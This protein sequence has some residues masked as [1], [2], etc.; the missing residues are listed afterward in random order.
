ME[1]KHPVPA[2]LLLSAVTVMAALAL[3][4]DEKRIE[5]SISV[6]P[7][8]K[9]L[10]DLTRS[11]CFPDLGLAGDG[12][13]VFGDKK[14][15]YVDNRE[16][17]A[18]AFREAGIWL[19]RPC[20]LVHAFNQ[21]AENPG[22][23]WKLDKK[24]KC[25]WLHPR[26]KFSFWKEYGIKAIVCLNIWSGEEEKKKSLSEFLKWIKA[27]GWEDCISG[28]EMCNEPFYGKDP[29]GFAAYWKD[30]LA[31]IRKE[32]PKVKI[33][34]PLAEYTPGDPDIAAAKARLLGKTKLPRDYFRANSLNQWSAKTVKALGPEL[35]NI[36]HIIYHVYGAAGAYGCSYTG[37]RRFR[38][39]A[40]MFPEV[41]DKRWWITEWRPWSDE[42]LQLQRQFHYVIWAGMYIQTCLCQPELDGFTMHQLS[43]LS[44]VVY[45]SAHGKWSQ[46]Y[47][48]WENGRDLK[49]IKKDELKYETGGM[50]VLF[51]LS[52]QA[53]KTHPLIIGYGSV[54]AG[55]GSEGAFWGSAHYE[56]SGLKKPNCQWTAMVNPGRSSL[57]IMFANGSD[58][59]LTV[60]VS[61]YGYRLLSKTHRFAT[62][63]RDMLR[64]REV[65]GEE[66]I[67][68]RL[69][70]ETPSTGDP[71]AV[72]TVTV[73]A[74]S[75]GTVFIGMKKWSDW[76]R[77]HYGR[78]QIKKTLGKVRSSVPKTSKPYIECCGVRKGS[79]FMVLPDGYPGKPEIKENLP[80]RKVCEAIGKDP[81]KLDEAAIKKAEA[82]GYKV[83]RNDA[84][85]C[86][87]VF[88]TKD[89]PE[90]EAAEIERKLREMAGF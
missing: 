21:I 64:A 32:M 53:I 80:A 86:A 29:E 28:F 55:P 2:R 31:I 41:A 54:L 3:R 20:G 40:K 66:K 42:N 44:G 18:R 33:G 65:P 38:N 11:T 26:Y 7:Y 74:N 17:T 73:P 8:A 88:R 1:M 45:I 27:N 34:L 43:S 67:L 87:W 84:S 22:V 76:E 83:F 10:K 82:D 46:Y 14:L 71:M 69:N 13:A 60:P 47:D 23:E 90:K 81:R 79:L 9:V 49:V 35:T 56:Q 68:R 70:W 62:C 75:V 59:K 12:S 15:S 61:C 30:L 63:D 72:Q 78:M 36:T 50:G 37:F 16:L 19:V 25:T 39:F 48:S 5:L 24:G 52:A 4:A 77:V 51:S 89:I 6:D 58:E 85:R 57:C